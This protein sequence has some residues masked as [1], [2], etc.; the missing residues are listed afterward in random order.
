MILLLTEI[1]LMDSKYQ[2][3]TEHLINTRLILSVAIFLVFLVCYFLTSGLLEK[4]GAFNDFDILFEMDTPRT[5]EDMT[6]FREDHSRTR[7]HPLY[8]LMVNPVGTT[9]AR[10]VGDEVLAARIINSILGAL[11]VA[12]AFA[13]FTR[14]GRGTIDAL[15]LAALFGV[16][17]SQFFISSIPDT[18]SLG[19]VSLILLYT[20]FFTS[21]KEQ[22][23]HFL[24]W[25]L[26]GLFTMGVTTTNFVQAGILFFVASLN[27]VAEKK[28]AK[29]FF[30]SLKYGLVV[31]GAGA[32]LALVQKAIY[33]TTELFF[34]PQ[35]FAGELG[36]A[37]PLI[38]EQP[39]V[40]L[41][42]LVR[43]FLLINIAAPAPRFFEI[44]GLGNPGVTFAA[45][46]D[47]SL[48]GWI[49]LALWVGLMLFSVG[50]ILIQKKHLLFYVGLGAC[51]AF[52]FLLHSFYGV[53]PTRI[54]LF[55][56]NGSLTFLVM[57][58]LV[59]AYLPKWENVFRFLLVVLVI[60]LAVNNFQAMQTI[61]QAMAG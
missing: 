16:T 11:G 41:S 44:P 33:Q 42:Y 52:N 30:Q 13:F 25:F 57:T 51:L 37:S 12:L 48:V 45:S 60:L 46:S 26:A 43:T 6:V 7:V 21:L 32:T 61:I 17:T 59:E 14:Y 23:V 49:A 56:Y 38:F 39:R 50:K 24:P 18:P 28:W 35:T 10:L 8:V 3:R 5:I 55:L 40:V 36:Y 58:P 34:L 54:E 1:Y 27:A 53:T 9:L 47:Y 29:A 31:L 20:L 22:R 2:I 15:I 19:V 4:A